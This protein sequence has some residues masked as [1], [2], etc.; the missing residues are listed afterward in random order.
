MN[1]EVLEKVLNLFDSCQSSG[2]SLEIIIDQYLLEVFPLPRKL[3]ADLL[4]DPPMSAMSYLS[5]DQIHF[6]SKIM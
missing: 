1:F 6:V 5:N 4:S 2:K 3:I